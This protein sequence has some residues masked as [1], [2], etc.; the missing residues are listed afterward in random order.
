MVTIGQGLGKCVYT[1]VAGGH[2]FGLAQLCLLIVVR[3]T[4]ICI[5]DKI[6]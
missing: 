2:L 4:E 6:S 1:G 3:C 5:C